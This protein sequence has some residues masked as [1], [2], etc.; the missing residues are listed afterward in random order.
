MS[1]YDQR[2]QQV[3]SQVNI[4]TLNVT[5]LSD[6]DPV[7]RATKD[8][9]RALYESRVRSSPHKASYHL[10]LGLYYIDCAMYPFAV[11]SLMA[12][13]QVAP[14]DP[15][16]LYY[17]ALATLGGR[18]PRSLK[19]AE[20]RAIETY[21]NT[22]IQGSGNRAHY[23]YLWAL[24]KHDYYAAN[25]LRIPPPSIDQLVKQADRAVFDVSE[26][27]HLLAHVP[28]HDNPLVDR[29]RLRR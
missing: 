19:M 20:I 28:V 6:L 15:N 21:L 3:G 22:A 7:D 11:S 25:G 14:M 17:L 9:L 27:R 16:I 23:F 13:H 12:A 5:M 2:N 29:I 4:N 24:V 8:R 10:T 18:P 26:V 1:S